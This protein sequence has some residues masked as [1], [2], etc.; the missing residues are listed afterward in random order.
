MRQEKRNSRQE[1]EDLLQK[2]GNKGGEITGLDEVGEYSGQDD[3]NLSQ[4]RAHK[5]VR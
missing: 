3:E 4:K 1:G 2:K 5:L